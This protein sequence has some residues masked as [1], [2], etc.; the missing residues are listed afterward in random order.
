MTNRVPKH[1]AFIMDGNSRWSKKNKLSKQIGY[2]KGIET[3]ENLIN[4]CINKKIKIL[5]VY[6]LSTE[7][8]YRKDINILYSIINNFINESKSLDRFKNIDF[9]LLGKR[10]NI[11]K[12][13]LSFFDKLEKN[14]PSTKKIILNLAYNYGSWSEL[15]NC[16]K[17]ISELY[18]DKKFKINEKKIRENLYTKNIPDPDLLIRTGGK[19]RLSNFLL[20]QLKYTELFFIDTLWPDFDERV[21][22][23]ILKEYQLINRTF[24]L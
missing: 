7:N 19:K 16:V 17:K 23:K 1:V 13:I 4:I 14:Q 12:K 15:E 18:K 20:L 9:R 3:L 22:L 11:N 21:F 24:G 8:I 5:T 2:K 6:A 10:E